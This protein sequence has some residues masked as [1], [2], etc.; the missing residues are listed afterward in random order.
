MKAVNLRRRGSAAAL[1]TGLA[2]ALTLTS[3]PAVAGPPVTADQSARP[4]VAIVPLVGNLEIVNTTADGQVE[5]ETQLVF[6][7]SEGRTRIEGATTVTIKDPTTDTTVILDTL[8]GT[9]QQVSAPD[10]PSLTPAGREI[11]HQ[12]LSSQPRALGESS[13]SGVAAVGREYTVTAPESSLRPSQD[14]TITVWSAADIQLPVH[15]RVV[16]SSGE[17]YQQTYTNLRLWREPS[18]ALFEIPAGYVPADRVAGP[19]PEQVTCQLFPSV[20]FLASFGGVLASG[21]VLADT[22]GPGCVFIADQAFFEPP[23]SGFPLNPLGLPFDDWFAFDT[24]APVPF[25]PWTSF[26][27][28]DY[29]AAAPG[30]PVTIGSSLVILDI[31]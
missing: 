26:G 24:G 19:M 28:I 8:A 25:L 12:P 20:L 15:T 17:V 18:P 14:Y 16:Q 22:V 31:F 3:A 13:F 29:A 4:S 11:S 30:G 9:Y 27:F 7:D 6:R 23:L 5:R 10:N 21:V 1:V 2:L